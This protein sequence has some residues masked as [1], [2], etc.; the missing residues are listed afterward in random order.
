MIHEFD[1]TGIIKRERRKGGKGSVSFSQEREY[2][3]GSLW[4]NPK[5]SFFLPFYL[6]SCSLHSSIVTS[7]SCTPPPQEVESWW[8]EHVSRNRSHYRGF[9]ADRNS[10]EETRDVCRNFHPP[11]FLSCSLQKI[12]PRREF[13]SSSRMRS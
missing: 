12:F 3:V 10:N 1:L 4:K 9:E 5:P 11:L 6:P 7:H 13:T 2:L 8:K